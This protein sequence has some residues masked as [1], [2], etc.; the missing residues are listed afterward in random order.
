MVQTI[1]GPTSPA[2][3]QTTNARSENSGSALPTP[4]SDCALRPAESAV[5]SLSIRPPSHATR[6]P[7]SESDAVALARSVADE[8]PANDRSLLA[9][10]G[11]L[12]R[13]RAVAAKLLVG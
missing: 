7:L 3:H 6:T 4:Q 12:D 2:F 5:D 1:H 8:L 11:D 13:L 9:Q 10:S